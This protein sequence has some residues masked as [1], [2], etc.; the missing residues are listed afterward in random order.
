MKV[1][2]GEFGKGTDKKQSP[3]ASQ[4]LTAMSVVAG[5][6]EQ[7]HGVDMDVALVLFLEGEMI[8]VVSNTEHPDATYV[9]LNMGASSI[10]NEILGGG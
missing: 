5:E 4:V 1:I 8:Q 10:M 2:Q 3:S 7:E 6:L 9:L